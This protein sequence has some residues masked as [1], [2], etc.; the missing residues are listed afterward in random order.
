MLVASSRQVIFRAAGMR[1]PEWK[2]FSRLRVPR[3]D[4]DFI[5]KALW[6]KPPVAERLVAVSKSLA[7]AFDGQRESHVHF[8]ER[9]QFAL[10]VH[11]AVAHTYGQAV[12][13]DGHHVNLAR[14]FW[15]KQQIAL[16]TVQGVLSWS[17]LASEWSVRCQWVI[18]KT[19][20]TM[21][22]LVAH[23]V[24]K[25]GYWMS[26][27]DQSVRWAEILPLLN[28]LRH[29]QEAGA[30]GAHWSCPSGLRKLLSL[31]ES[32]RVDAKRARHSHTITRVLREWDDL[33]TKDWVAVFTGGSAKRVGGWNQAGFGCYYGD[34]HPSTFSDF[35]PVGQPQTNN[36]AEARAMLRVGA[37]VTIALD[38]EYVYDGLTK[39]ILR[40]ERDFW[41]TG[42]GPVAHADLWIQLLACMRLHQTSVRFFWLPSHVGIDG[43]EGADA[44]VEQGRLQHPYNELRQAKRHWLDAD[45]P[46]QATDLPSECSWVHSE[47][48]GAVDEG[49]SVSSVEG[50]ECNAVVRE[51][52]SVDEPMS[53]G[54]EGSG[55]CLTA[56]TDSAL[57]FDEYEQFLSQFLGD[58][59]PR[60]GN[61][62]GVRDAQTYPG[63]PLSASL[64]RYPLS[65][66]CA[67]SLM[68]V[69]DTLYCLL[70]SYEPRV[71][72]ARSCERGYLV[73]QVSV[74]MPETICTNVFVLV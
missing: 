16:T 42:A 64:G 37:R 41:R 14:G 39:H 4:Y 70:L 32:Q 67:L 10:F 44:L 48:G 40:W 47:E 29:W 33:Q 61:A 54:S 21:H 71:C 73:S 66:K 38:S 18:S 19:V 72:V 24:A 53:A 55:D 49:T 68:Y 35:V 11:N 15:Q 34:R 60:Q 52:G 69:T 28:N 26:C 25:L 3:F 45:L 36:R 17:G 59:E 6:L 2:V 30:L 20:V 9:C 23:W 57:S 63:F 31:T 27:S 1:G 7:C 12:N 56:S 50:D 74:S 5:R 8:L 13:A 58:D 51:E 65:T 46:R 22:T 43:N 62:T